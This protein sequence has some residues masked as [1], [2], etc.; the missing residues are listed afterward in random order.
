MAE[1]TSSAQAV[2][3]EH[4]K[5]PWG[6]MQPPEAAT[7]DERLWG[8]LANVLAIVVLGPVVAWLVKGESKF[9]KFNALQMIFM[10]V[11]SIACSIVLTILATVL[12][13]LVLPLSGLVSLAFLVALVVV[14][15]KAHGGVIFKLP[16]IGGIAYK[17][18]YGA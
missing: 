3:A 15:I 5:A 13:A 7:A 16:V 18:I 9:V 4:L 11:V 17:A 2:A 10:F 1:N 6:S 8:M 12:G 14:A